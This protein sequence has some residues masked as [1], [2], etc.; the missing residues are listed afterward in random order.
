MIDINNSTN[1]GPKS[2]GEEGGLGM[3]LASHPRTTI[4]PGKILR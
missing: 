4:D 1:G 3:K 2:E